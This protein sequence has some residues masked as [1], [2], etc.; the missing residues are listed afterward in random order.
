MIDVKR[1]RELAQDAL[2]TG[3]WYN[4]G[5]N[6]LMCTYPEN[7]GD[8]SGESDEIAHPTPLGLVEYMA[9]AQPKVILALC[10]RLEAAEKDA[11]KIEQAAREVLNWTEAKHRPPKVEGV[12][13]G[14]M[15][16]VRVHA[17]VELHAALAQRQ[18][19]GS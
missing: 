16:L 5:C 19:E 8:L 17:L 14:E 9:A 1:L 11:E 7:S 12:P 13:T 6:T 2:W 15:A 18:G 10:D 3:N 4:A